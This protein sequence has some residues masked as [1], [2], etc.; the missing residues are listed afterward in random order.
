MARR[1]FLRQA[2]MTALAAAAARAAHAVPKATRRRAQLERRL[3][4]YNTHTTEAIDAVYWAEGTYV[5]EGL[6]LIDHVLRDH[7]TGDVRPMDRQLLDLLFQLRTSLETTTKPFHI[8]SGFRT[9]E[10][11][12]YL[13]GL[14]P[15]SGV[16]RQSQ[17]M[18]GRATD[19]RIPGVAIETIRAA[20]LA[21]KRGGVGYYPASDF[22]HVDVGRVRTW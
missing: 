7:R 16:A 15:A 13:R 14:S 18:L 17:H 10:S 21:L 12:A 9:P 3:A 19:I 20:A 8:I 2:A 1:E 11:N 4:F 6:R 5:P 22:V